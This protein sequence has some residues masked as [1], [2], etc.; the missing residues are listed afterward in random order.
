MSEEKQK[1]G[2]NMSGLFNA[3]IGFGEAIRNNL[4]ALEKVGV[5]AKPINFNMQLGHRLNDNSVNFDDNIN[6]YPVNIVHVNMD[7]IWSFLKEKSSEF[8]ENKYNIGYWAWEMEEFPDE[9]VEYFKYYDEIWT[10]SKYCLDS[11]SL[12]SDIPVINIPHAID[13]DKKDINENFETD[14]TGESYH[15]LFIFD[16]NSLI[17]RKNTLAVIDAYEK[18][19]GK[20]NGKVKLVL[21][22]SIPGSHLSKARSQVKTRIGNNKSII[23]K[24][25]MLRRNDL[26]ALMN[27]ANCY[28]SLHRSEGFGLTMAEAMALGKPVIA[29]GY[30]GNLDFMNINNSFLVKYKMIKH[31]YDLSVLPKNNYWSDPDTDHAAELMK[32]VFENQSYASEIGKK[33]KEDIQNYFSLDAIGKKMKKRLEIIENTILKE[34]D[35]Q[36]VKNNLIKLLSENKILQKRVTYLEKGFYNKA[37][38]KINEILKKIKGRN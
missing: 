34:R 16:Y 30:S 14:L 9:Y 29:T 8:F 6:D 24:E 25:E 11:M 23:Y 36:E 13:I 31:E 1:F 38:K 17:E 26:L 4:K 27:K 12:K 10:C 2:V 35:N 37:R 18:A 5:P 33:A 7:T 32:F 21:K 28:I 20:D 3:E 15:F 22:T 19:F